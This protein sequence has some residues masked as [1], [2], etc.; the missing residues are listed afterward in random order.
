MAPE[1][2]MNA[3]PQPGAHPN[4]LGINGFEFV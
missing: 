1:D 2:R 4:P 3:Q